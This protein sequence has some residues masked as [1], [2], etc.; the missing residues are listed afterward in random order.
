M[1]NFVFKGKVLPV[2]GFGYLIPTSENAKGVLGSG[3]L[4]HSVLQSHGGYLATFIRLQ[5]LRCL[6]VHVLSSTQ[7]FVPASAGM[8]L[9][10]YP[11]YTCHFD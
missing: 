8:Y 5:M 11:E 2:E 3:A 4:K 1:V 7:C 10:S 9:R 6:T